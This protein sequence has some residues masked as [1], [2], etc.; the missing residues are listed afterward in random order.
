MSQYSVALE[1]DV[2]VTVHRDKF[3]IMK[4][5][6]CTNFSNL[7]LE[8]NS[9]CFGHFLCPT[10]W[11]FHCTHS[12]GISHTG[13]LTACEQDQDGTKFNP[14]PARKLS[15]NL[16]D[17]RGQSKKK[18]NI[19]N[20]ASVSQRGMLATVVLCRGDFKLY[21]H[22]NHITPLQLVIELRGLEWTCV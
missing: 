10:S 6:R 7:F 21:F 4:P 13:F 2:H 11:V 14:D 3:L 20:L 16:C 9:T 15:A 22:T 12:N 8:W 1:L 5:T 18:P 17:I 19:W